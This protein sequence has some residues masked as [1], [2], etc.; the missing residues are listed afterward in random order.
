MVA[1]LKLMYFNIKIRKNDQVRFP[2]HYALLNDVI[3]SE[4]FIF[5][6]ILLYELNINR[7]KMSLKNRKRSIYSSGKLKVILSFIFL[8]LSN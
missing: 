7:N 3:P 2:F 1:T 5:L 6:F 4:S 8:N